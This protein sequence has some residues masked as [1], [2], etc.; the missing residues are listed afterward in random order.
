MPSERRL[1]PASIVFGLG[2]QVREFAVPLLVA[3]LAGSRR[4]NLDVLALP[5]LVIY[6]AIAFGRYYS[7]RYR[8]EPHELVVRSGLIFRNERHIP[9][10]RV[11]NIDA[12]R[13]VFHRALGVV[14]V[15][16][17]TGSGA[18]ADARLSVV[19]W[20]AY[21]ELRERVLGERDAF[22]GAD[23]AAPA[24]MERRTLLAL[25]AREIALQGLIENRGT[26]VIAGLFGLLWEIGIADRYLNR[27][28]GDEATGR[29]LVRD[30]IQNVG[31]PQAMPWGRLGTAVL[32]L[33]ALLVFLRLL[34][35]ALA[36]V[37]LGGFQLSRIGDDLRAE[38]GLLTRVAATIPLRRIQTL[39]ITEGPL[40][41]LF[42]RA[43]IRVDTAGGGTGGRSET[44]RESLAPIIGRDEWP[45]L[46][47]QVLPEVDLTDV[48]WHGAAPGAR[49]R[50]IRVRLIV[51]LVVALLLSIPLGWAALGVFAV[52]AGW[53]VVA[54]ILTVKHFAWATIDGAV[55]MRSGWL[56]RHMSVARF[57]RI[58]SVSLYESPFDRRW[59]MAR[60]H[61][62]TAG[63]GAASHRVHIPYLTRETAV[64]LHTRLAAAAASTAFSW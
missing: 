61:V 21:E 33:A 8:F 53:G 17:D 26:I 11:Q 20:P 34:S 37:R 55:L 45:A 19:G 63:A 6:A 18:D 49:T 31:V 30:L 1:H 15:R 47:R 62:D 35:I 22:A 3:V 43:S 39:T 41:R 44:R 7:F 9:Y 50:A 40:H 10:A 59:G 29:G 28:V 23:E 56:W 51:A 14:N 54:A 58:Q 52:L 13:N 36:L 32:L 12:V 48:T 16:I 25:P 42:G 57:A 2:A 5:V 60:V 38:Y 46:V 24:A 64:A 4:G 27:F